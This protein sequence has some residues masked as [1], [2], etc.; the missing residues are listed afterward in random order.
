MYFEEAVER[1]MSG[2][3][4]SIMAYG[5]TGSGK[6]HTM[7][8][9]NWPVLLNLYAGMLVDGNKGR[10]DI[11]MLEKRRGLVLSLSEI[12]FKKG[13]EA[14]E[15]P[16]IFVKYYQ[17]YNEKV[18]DLFGG[19]DDLAIQVD[20]LGVSHIENISQIQV[21]SYLEFLLFLQRAES[22]RAISSTSQNSHSSRSHT[23]FEIEVIS[24]PTT[25]ARLTLCDLAG[26]EKLA[27]EQIRDKSQQE[28]SKYI[29]R[30]L[31]ALSR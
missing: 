2:K 8:G 12:L 20:A 17:V 26:S 5:N 25:K 31:S 22:R 15:R 29:N 10:H 1:V 21:M 7:Y 30:S 18:S 11:L 27:L 9:Q 14:S 4:C 13:S 23:I 3:H 6:T 24:N 28:E 16:S 19:G